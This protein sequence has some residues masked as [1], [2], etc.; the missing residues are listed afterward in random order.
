M[1]PDFVK[2]PRRDYHCIHPF[3]TTTAGRMLGGRPVRVRARGVLPVGET[4]ALYP[5]GTENW[6]WEMVAGMGKSY[7]GAFFGT[8]VLV[9]GYYL[10]QYY[11]FWV[12]APSLQVLICFGGCCAL[13][14]NR[15][16]TKIARIHSAGGV[17]EGGII[18]E[19][20]KYKENV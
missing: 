10:V 17:L 5:P 11:F 14:C 20:T 6:L 18:L 9:I 13:R 1:L 8:T 19:C 3:I 2:K 15:V 4:P 12:Q 16:L 7:K